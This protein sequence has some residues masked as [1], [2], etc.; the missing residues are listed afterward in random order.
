[1]LWKNISQIIIQAPYSCLFI[2]PT[3]PPSPNRAYC[4]TRTHW[5]VKTLKN[6]CMD[7]WHIKYQRRFSSFQVE[8]HRNISSIQLMG[9]WQKWHPGT[10]MSMEVEG[11]TLL[12]WCFRADRFTY[13]LCH[14]TFIR[15][16][17]AAVL[18][19]FTPFREALETLSGFKVWVW[20]SLE[21]C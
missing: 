12:M 5:K 19:F 17:R 14:C 13:L 21:T 4:K 3:F 15:K 8:M 1:M 11:G 10:A 2:T 18:C 16:L 20:R 9:K 6:D 7:E